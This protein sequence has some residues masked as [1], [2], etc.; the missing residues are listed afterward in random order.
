MLLCYSLC[1]LAPNSNN[2]K[3]SLADKVHWSALHG[4][5]SLTS[6]S[7][8][9]HRSPDQSILVKPASAITLS[10]VWTP[11]DKSAVVSKVHHVFIYKI[12]SVL[13]SFS[14]LLYLLY[15]L[16]QS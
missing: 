16:L 14:K 8:D 9:G 12:D 1:G 15:E 7:L 5:T 3:C 6:C 4:L 10:V 11:V 2:T 13:Q